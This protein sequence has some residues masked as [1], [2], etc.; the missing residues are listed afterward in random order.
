V[1]PILSIFHRWKVKM[2]DKPGNILKKPWGNHEIKLRKTLEK[3]RKILHKP[4]KN[5]K[6]SLEKLGKPWENL[7][8][9]LKI[10]ENI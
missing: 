8:I 4:R 9:F 5:L 2:M 10:F 7:G 1:K 6:K 3:F